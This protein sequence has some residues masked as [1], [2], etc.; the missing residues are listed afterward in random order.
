MLTVVKLTAKPPLVLIVP[1][2]IIFT[3]PP[4][5]IKFNESPVFA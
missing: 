5:G 2:P 1:A 3:L 4:T